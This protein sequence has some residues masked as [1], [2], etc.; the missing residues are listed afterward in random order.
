M[1]TITFA[2]LMRDLKIPGFVYIPKL[3]CLVY[4]TLLL[5]LLSFLGLPSM[6][7]VDPCSLSWE[8]W[9]V[10]LM[11]PRSRVQS[12]YGPGTWDPWSL[13]VSFSAYSVIQKPY[14]EW[15]FSRPCRFLD[16]VAILFWADIK[17]EVTYWWQAWC[18]NWI[19]HLFHF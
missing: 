7:I 8:N 9:S 16:P 17:A 13:C 3:L 2:F 12:L 10:L 18:F 1:C 6:N 4:H 15:L 11:T 5:Q 14:G 19:G